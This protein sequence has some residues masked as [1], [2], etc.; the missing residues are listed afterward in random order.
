MLLDIVI[1]PPRGLRE[2]IG[3]RARKAAAGIKCKYLIDNRKLIPHVS[4]FHIRTDRAGYIKIQKKLLEISQEAKPFHMRAV[5]FES[6]EGSGYFWIRYHN[7]KS[8]KALHKKVL[9]ELHP[10][11]RGRIISRSLIKPSASQSR[12]WKKYGSPYILKLLTPHITIGRLKDPDLILQ[13]KIAGRFG[14]LS[15]DFKNSE[16]ALCE[17]NHDCQVNKILKTFKLKNSR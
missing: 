7:S 8:F 12:Y 9:S 5:G 2:K 15:S 6:P 10:L 16:L 3:A 13:R 14:Q 11:R 17:V 1:L 4:L